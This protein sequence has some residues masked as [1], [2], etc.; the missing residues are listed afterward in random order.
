[1]IRV[2]CEMFGFRPIFNVASD[3]RSEQLA[4]FLGLWR[5]KIE[6]C[7]VYLPS[8]CVDKT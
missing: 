1:M 8:D 4:A 6:V 5:K 7:N 3:K 2:S